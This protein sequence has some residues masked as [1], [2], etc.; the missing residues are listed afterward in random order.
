MSTT[1]EPTRRNVM[2]D[3][4]SAFS[5]GVLTTFITQPL[6]T[7][8]TRFQVQNISKSLRYTGGTFHTLATIAREEGPKALYRGLPPSILSISLSMALYFPVYQK[9]RESISDYANKSKNH[10]LVIWPSVFTGWLVSSVIQC[11]PVTA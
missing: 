11:P 8:K 6:D 10:P 5:S 1:D 7:V 3:I 9:C 2:H 4:V